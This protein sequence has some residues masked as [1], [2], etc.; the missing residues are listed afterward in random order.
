MVDTTSVSLLHNL[1]NPEN[2]GAWSRFDS[3]Y[4]E[5]IRRFLLQRGL[6]DH[7]VDDICQNTMRQVYQA[8]TGDRFEHNGNKGAFRNWL[9][10]V[11]STQLAL[12][13]RKA[14][15]Q[16]L[17]LTDGLEEQL[18]TEDSG[19]VRLWNREHNRALLNVIVDLLS[20]HTSPNA[21]AIFRRMCVDGVSADEVA[22]EFGRTRNAVVVVKSRL[23]K[24]AR[25]LVSGVA[26]F[27]ALE[28][29]TE[30]VD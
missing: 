8:L 10:R 15:R 13:R 9:R 18:L 19:L 23:L 6:D 12:H 16:E 17:E 28:N 26:D 24:K 7:L 11:V 30:Q 4:R 27:D 21:L 14:T 5:F 29:L 2:E 20:E 25:K 1:R 3:R 22:N